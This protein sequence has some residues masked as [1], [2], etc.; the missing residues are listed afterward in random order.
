MGILVELFQILK[1]DA[2]KCYTQYVS[3]SGR[4][5]SG[6]RTRKGQTSPQFPRRVVQK[7]VLAIRQ[8]YSS[9][10]LVRSRLKS[11]MLGFSIMQTNNFQMSKLALEKEEELEVKLPTFTGSQRKLGNTRKTST[12]VSSVMLKPLTVCIIINCGKLFE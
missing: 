9:P 12:S 2:L 1:D 5:S 7:K 3:K 10:M 4:P 11:C 6:L 8:S